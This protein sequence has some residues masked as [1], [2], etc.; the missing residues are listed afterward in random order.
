M[1]EREQR[2]QQKIVER[3]KRMSVRTLA[4]AMKRRDRTMAQ[5]GI[6]AVVEMILPRR[7]HLRDKTIHSQNGNPSMTWYWPTNAGKA[8][9]VVEVVGSAWEATRVSLFV[10]YPG[11]QRRS[12]M[13]YRNIATA[14]TTGSVVEHALRQLVAR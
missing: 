2:F 10:S 14:E 1:G 4:R 12:R 6:R 3:A 8:N 11:I 7:N 9:L 5:R 13:V